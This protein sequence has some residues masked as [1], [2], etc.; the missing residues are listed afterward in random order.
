M[1]T[2]SQ[3]AD[4]AIRRYDKRKETVLEMKTTFDQKYINILCGIMTESVNVNEISN[5]MSTQ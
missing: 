3:L 4:L 2:I 5:S 1:I